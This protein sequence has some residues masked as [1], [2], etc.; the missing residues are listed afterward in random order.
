MTHEGS[1]K[2]TRLRPMDSR[3]CPPSAPWKCWRCYR[4]TGLACAVFLLVAAVFWGAE[5]AEYKTIPAAKTSELTPALDVQ[6]RQYTTWYRSHGDSA[7]T[8]YSSLK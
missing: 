7:G 2:A 8:R 5:P 6:P 3:S 4:I 1:L